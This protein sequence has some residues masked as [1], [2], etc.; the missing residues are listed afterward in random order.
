MQTILGAGGA[1]GKPLATELKNY[2][3]KI[4]LVG[5][6]PQKVNN[7]D[8]L[9]TADITH[10]EDLDR[11]IAG[12]EIVYSVVGFEYKASVWKKKWPPFMENLIRSC[13]TH[14]AKLVFFDNIYMYDRDHLDGMTEN[15]P[16]RPSSKKGRVRQVVARMI[17]DEFTRNEI[18]ALIARAP[19]FMGTHNSVPYE[20]I[21]KNLYKGKKAMWMASVEKVH[22]F[23]YPQDAARAT[24]LLGNTPGAFNQVWHLPAPKTKLTGKD[25]IHLFAEKMGKEP[26]YTVMKKGMLQFAGIFVPIL[27][28]MAEMIYQYDRDYYFLSDKFEQEFSFEITSPEK[29]VE[30][31][32]KSNPNSK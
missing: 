8:E 26:R 1:I 14:N 16:I 23:I 15:T 19:D 4:R 20:M 6:N 17:E 21:Y 30:E 5:R 13:K 10:P 29:M 7:D 2:T 12:S 31:I 28:E 3:D 9:F 25:W 11:S 27:K 32:I 18:Q 22:N 24:A